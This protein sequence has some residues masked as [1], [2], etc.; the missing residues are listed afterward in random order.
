MFGT[1]RDGYPA[2]KNALRLPTWQN[3]YKTE[4]LNEEVT[5]SDVTAWSK[6]GSETTDRV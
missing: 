4:L 5:C 3:T 2:V 6:T 1:F